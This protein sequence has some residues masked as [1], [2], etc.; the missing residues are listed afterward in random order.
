MSDSLSPQFVA[1]LLR[2]ERLTLVG[3][4]L[5]GL[6]HNLSGGVQMMRLPLD[7]LELK[8]AH[9]ASTN[10]LISKLKALQEG[11]VRV[12]E[13]ITLLAAH[14]NQMGDAQPRELD[15]AALVAEQVAFWR[16]DLFFKHQ[17]TLEGLPATGLGKVRVAYRD[18]ALAV[19][20][21]LNNAVEAMD[22]SRGGAGGERAVLRVWADGDGD[23]YILR[24]RDGGPGPAEE[25]IPSLGAPFFTTKGAEHDGLGLFLAGQAL[26]PWG[27]R[28]YWDRR[29]GAF[30]IALPMLTY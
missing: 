7:L 13:E 26:A 1:A 20:L 24:L 17:M 18:L 23:D 19:N 22:Q 25:I 6:V 5:R 27:G 14:G 29:E 15:P 12:G 3:R 10:D 9:G 21:L 30:A 4:L 2:R 8:L 28:V 11:V 16:G